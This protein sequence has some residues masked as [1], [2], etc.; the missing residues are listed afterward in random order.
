MYIMCMC[1]PLVV[2]LYAKVLKLDRLYC[3]VCHASFWAVRFTR[4]EVGMLLG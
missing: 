3:N 4:K 1:L 2:E